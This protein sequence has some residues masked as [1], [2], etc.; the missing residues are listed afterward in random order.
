M[1][2]IQTE[3][4]VC[5]D[6]SVVHDP[7]RDFHANL[8]PTGYS[9]IMRAGPTSLPAVR[10]EG[11]PPLR[12]VGSEAFIVEEESVHFYVLLCHNPADKPAMRLTA[13]RLPE[14]GI[15]PRLDKGELPPGRSRQEEPE[16]LIEHINAATVFV[17]PSG[18][19]PWQN[20][21]LRPSSTNS[22]NGN[23]RSSRRCHRPETRARVVSPRRPQQRAGLVR[24]DDRP[25]VV[26]PAP[27]EVV[28][29]QVDRGP[30]DR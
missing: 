22:R 16:K 12:S 17:W 29:D 2:A 26:V 14:R 20:R 21:E 15:R 10:S 13:E 11:L 6:M 8:D 3:V 1:A 18:I 30:R 4:I 28:V 5:S 19:G 7:P 27:H 24:L 9:A 23:A 25:D